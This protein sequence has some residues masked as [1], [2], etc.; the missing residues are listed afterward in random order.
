[1]TTL[2]YHNVKEP[3][4]ESTTTT[5]RRRFAG[6]PI[7]KVN[8]FLILPAFNIANTWYGASHIVGK[9]NY[10][11]DKKFSLLTLPTRPNDTFCLAIT[12][13][14][15][16]Y[17][18]WEDIG[19]IFY[20]DLYS[21]S[22]TISESFS[23]EIWNVDGEANAINPG[24]LLLEISSM[25]LPNLNQLNCSTLVGADKSSYTE[26]C[27]NTMDL[28]GFDPSTEQFSFV[29]NPCAGEQIPL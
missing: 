3:W 20:F 26:T 14:N 2:P 24:P 23:L 8:D 7:T 6:T 28:T 10:T 9:Y 27:D 22:K 13:N 29:N 25:S 16:R 15:Q 5:P 18:L 17:K 21:G 4:A 19:E 11:I 12:F 1:M